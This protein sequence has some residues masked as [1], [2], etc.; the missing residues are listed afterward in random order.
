MQPIAR[1]FGRARRIRHPSV[2]LRAWRKRH[3]NFGQ[4]LNAGSTPGS[5]RMDNIVYVCLMHYK[6]K[7]P[8]FGRGAFHTLKKLPYLA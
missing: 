2:N 8:H 1:A 7:A 3:P 4:R 6:T 5:R